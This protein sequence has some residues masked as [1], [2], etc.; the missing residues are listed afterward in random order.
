MISYG[1]QSLWIVTS[2]FEMIVQHGSVVPRFVLCTIDHYGFRP[3]D[4]L[5]VTSLLNLYPV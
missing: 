1:Q 3:D 4:D 2:S 5:D